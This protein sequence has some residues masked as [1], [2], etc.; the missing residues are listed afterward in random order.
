MGGCWFLVNFNNSLTLGWM[1]VV[2]SDDNNSEVLVKFPCSPTSKLFHVVGQ[3]I[4]ENVKPSASNSSTRMYSP[5]I[6]YVT[7]TSFKIHYVTTN[8][9]SSVHALVNYIGI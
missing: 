1:N 8:G 9:S 4:S 5:I 3:V 7:L 6:H 2:T